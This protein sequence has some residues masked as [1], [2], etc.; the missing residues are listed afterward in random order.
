MNNKNLIKY[1]SG[2]TGAITTAASL[3]SYYKTVNDISNKDVLKGT[4]D[5]MIETK[6]SIQRIV[7]NN[8]QISEELSHNL[9]LQIKNTYDKLELIKEIAAKESTPEARCKTLLEH[10]YDKHPN[11]N[12]SSVSNDLESVLNHY[13]SKSGDSSLRPRSNSTSSD[14]LGNTNNLLDNFNSNNNNNI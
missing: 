4:I 3:H 1:L 5:E 2:L 12:F 8:V 9:A 7:D 6:E 10:I 14:T 11:P 13:A